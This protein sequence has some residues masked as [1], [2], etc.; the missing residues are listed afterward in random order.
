MAAHVAQNTET[1]PTTFYWANKWFLSRMAVQVDLETA[2][3]IEHFPTIM[4]F[5]FC[6]AIWGIIWDQLA[7]RNRYASARYSCRNIVL[8]DRG[9]L[10]VLG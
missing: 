9:A 10:V 5:I 4:A 1:S 8:C 3:A 2:G 6:G 7:M